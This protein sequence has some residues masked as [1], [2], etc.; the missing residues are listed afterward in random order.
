MQIEFRAHPETTG[1]DTQPRQDWRSHSLG[2]G[3][4]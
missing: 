2:D 1:N 3:H 4:A